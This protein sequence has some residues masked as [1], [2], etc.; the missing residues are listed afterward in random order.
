MK[1]VVT[2]DRYHRLKPLDE[3]ELI[4]FYDDSKGIVEEVKNLGT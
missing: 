4:G 3:A 1:I 2:Y